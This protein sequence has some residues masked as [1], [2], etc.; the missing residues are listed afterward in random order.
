MQLKLVK[1]NGKTRNDLLAALATLGEM[2]ADF[3][4][5]NG[6]EYLWD[7][8]EEEEFESNMEYLL[9]NI[10]GIQSDKELI[11]NFIERW[12]AFDSYYKDHALEVIYDK[13]GKAEYIALALVY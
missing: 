9:N 7:E 10:K 1:V 3:C 8:A 4:G 5:D 12:I 13:N 2:D 11:E 6:E